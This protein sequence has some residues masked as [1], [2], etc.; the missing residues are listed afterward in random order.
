M[1]GVIA[2]KDTGTGNVVD[3]TVCNGAIRTTI[4]DA[5]TADAK[6]AQFAVCNGDILCRVCFNRAGY[7]SP[8]AIVL[9]IRTGLCIIVANF[10]RRQ[11]RSIFKFHTVK[12]DIFGS[13]KDQK[14][15][16][17]R[18][19][20]RLAIH[21]SVWLIIKFA[22]AAVKIPFAGLVDKFIRV[23]YP[24]DA[25]GIGR[26]LERCEPIRIK[27][28]LRTVSRHTAIS[29]DAVLPPAQDVD[30]NIRS[31]FKVFQSKT[32][33]NSVTKMLQIII[34]HSVD[35]M[36]CGIG[37]IAVIVQRRNTGWRTRFTATHLH[38]NHAPYV[39]EIGRCI[40]LQFS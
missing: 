3:C 12:C 25:V 31:V 28:D 26:A 29:E 7:I 4:A 37:L 8:N 38:I 21:A 40:S 15:L 20:R 30:L 36:L 6:I 13:L 16:R 1:A 10:I 39:N 27:I 34:V 17:H 9:G 32:L 11:P 22:F 14:L 33:R 35:G 5:D 2:D 19:S 24:C 18:Q 23:F